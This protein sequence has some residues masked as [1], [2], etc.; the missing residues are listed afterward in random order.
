MA[1]SGGKKDQQHRRNR[2][3]RPG[4][5]AAYRDPKPT[6]LV[7]CEGEM[8]EPQYLQ[9]FERHFRNARLTFEISDEHGVPMTLVRTAKRL[10][11]E[12]ETEAHRER[13]D[14][15]AYDSVWCVFDVDE[16]P[17]V[18]NA[19]E[20]ARDNGIELAV[21][22]PCFELWLLLHFRDNP[23]MK[24]RQEIQQ[25]LAEHVTGYVKH[26][27]YSTYSDGYP[28]AVTR[29]TQLDA[30]AELDGDTGRNPTTGVYKL[31]ELIRCE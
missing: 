11:T 18:P 30:A 5:P 25:M 22:N 4:R 16:H 23:G 9:G 21:S 28:E 29:A 6:V 7:V 27:D 31:T 24:S 13:D 15:I 20:M 14:N 8:T 17:E 3:R 10:K 26:V 2:P 19:R 12:A 1:R